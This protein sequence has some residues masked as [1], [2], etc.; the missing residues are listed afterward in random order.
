MVACFLVG[1]C[2]VAIRTG[3][4]FSQKLRPNKKGHGSW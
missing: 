4:A 3:E 1:V 2:F